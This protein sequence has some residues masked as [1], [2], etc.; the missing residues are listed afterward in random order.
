MLLSVEYSPQ[1]I[2][3]T[4]KGKAAHVSLLR[5]MW[6]AICPPQEHL[7]GETEIEK[8]LESAT[9]TF[10]GPIV[11]FPEIARTNNQTVLTFGQAFKDLYHV[12]LNKENTHRGVFLQVLK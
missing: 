4:M 6:L 7:R 10:S 5:M 1:F 9:G 12:V 3:F 2:V 11:C 8:A